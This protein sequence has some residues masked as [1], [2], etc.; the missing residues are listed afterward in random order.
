MLFSAT[1]TAEEVGRKYSPE[2]LYF[3]LL[4]PGISSWETVSWFLEICSKHE[5]DS[6]RFTISEKDVA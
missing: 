4:G 2:V 6:L 3:F 1:A 5:V